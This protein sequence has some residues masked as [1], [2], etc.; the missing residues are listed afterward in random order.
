MPEAGYL[1]IPAKLARAG[2]KDMVRISDARMSGT[3]YGTIV[4][5]VSP[6]SATGGPLALVRNGDRIRLSV[7]ARTIDLLVPKE[8]LQRRKAAWKPPVAPPARGYAKLY[9]DHVLQAEHGCD[10]DFLRKAT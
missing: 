5:H 10:F 8:E 7:K 6:E 2:L 3:A 9:M 4:L 1:P